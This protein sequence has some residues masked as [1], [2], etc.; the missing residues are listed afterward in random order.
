MNTDRSRR[1][2]LR[3]KFGKTAKTAL[4]PPWS[5]ADPQF[6]DACSRCYACIAACPERIIVSGDGGF[7]EIDFNCGECV[8]CRACVEACAEPVFWDPDEIYPWEIVAAVGD[9]CLA[10]HGVFCQSCRESCEA[11]AIAFPLKPGRT[12]VPSINAERCTGCGACV[13]VCPVAAVSVAKR[14]ELYTEAL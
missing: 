11:G 6:S 1:A 12:V 9:S 5:K 4:R 7:P 2:F 13:S 8:F 10:Y 14:G 3:G